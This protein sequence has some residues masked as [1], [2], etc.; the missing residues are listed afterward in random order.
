MAELDPVT[1]DQLARL[2]DESF[3]VL[4]ESIAHMPD[5]STRVWDQSSSA[6]KCPSD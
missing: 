1:L 5:T 3:S 6:G 4:V 2:D